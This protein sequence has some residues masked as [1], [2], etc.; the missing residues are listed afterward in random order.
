MFDLSGKRVLVVGG[1]SGI[2]RGA[3]EAAAMQ[4]AAVTIASRSA[5]K[6]AA[7]VKAVG[8]GAEGRP[9][10]VTD[11]AAVAAFFKDGVPW[12][13]V[14]VSG[15]QTK[16]ALVKELPLADAYA[17]MNSKFWGAY[18]VARAA[19]IAPGG[20]LTLVSGFL[21]IRPRKGAAIQGAINAAVE[22]LT[23][24]LALELAP[25]RVNAVSPGLIDTPMYDR[26]PA[27][28]RQAMYERNAKAIPSGRVGRAEDVAA[29]ILVFMANPF[30][31]GSVVYL[32]GGGALV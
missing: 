20:S 21:S 14:V 10:D 25:V 4:G 8:H 13:H 27:D 7:A 18:R 11:E 12:D 29:Q 15:A 32:D 26:M 3:A 22:A 17:S 9:L 5:E 31:T 28:Q 24:G 1:S 6:V 16:V 19:T 23:Q 2:G 30:M